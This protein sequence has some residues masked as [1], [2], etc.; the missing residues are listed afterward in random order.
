MLAR[1]Q[2]FLRQRG[3]PFDE[4]AFRRDREVIRQV[5]R[6]ELIEQ[7]WGESEGYRYFLTFDPQ[8]KK[9]REVIPRAQQMWSQRLQALRRKEASS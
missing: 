8:F 1:F 5:L 4:A 7:L 6:R 2:D 9:A 3:I